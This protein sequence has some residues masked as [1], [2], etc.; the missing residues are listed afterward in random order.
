[1]FIASQKKKENVSEYILYM[2]KIEDIIRT[3]QFDI[4]KIKTNIISR[5]QLDDEKRTQ[6]TEW[7]ESLIDMMLKEG[8]REK[9]HLQ[10]VTN[11]LNELNTL[12]KTLLM[13]MKYP[14]YTAAYYKA[15]PFISELRAKENKPEANDMDVAL[16]FLYGILVLRLKGEKVTE[17]TSEALTV[18]TKF[19]ARLSVLYNDYKADKLDLE[20]A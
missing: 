6:L 18:V 14:E 16:S 8:E 10:M 5:F 19:L 11:T 9:G 12:H 17:Q 1:M 4:D 20:I 2:W 13:S 7:Y 15:L 3:F